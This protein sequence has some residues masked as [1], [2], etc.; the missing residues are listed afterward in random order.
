VGAGKTGFFFAESG[1]D[2]FTSE[3][4]GNEYGLAASSVVGGKASETVATID[5]LFNV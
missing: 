1:L 2:F 3:D 4:E 5:E